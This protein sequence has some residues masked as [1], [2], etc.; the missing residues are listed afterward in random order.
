MARQAKTGG[1]PAADRRIRGAAGFTLIEVAIVLAII[2]AVTAIAVPN[3]DR[4]FDGI[5]GRAAARSPPR[6]PTLK[7]KNSTM[8]GRCSQKKETLHY[9]GET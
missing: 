8:W 4:Y 2:G 1:R 6:R 3:V 7:K 5:N 9:T